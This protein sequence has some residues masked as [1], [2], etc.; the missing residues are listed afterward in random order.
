MEKT[1]ITKEGLEK[2]KEELITIKKV[3][4]PDNI[5]AIEE[6]RAH[7]DIS[8]NAEYHAAKEKQAFIEG[9]MNKLEEIISS[10]EVIE[11]NKGPLERI[12]F[13]AV[14]TTAMF[15][16]TTV[17]GVDPLGPTGRGPSSTYKLV[18][19]YESDPK[20]NRI[21]VTSPLGAALIGKDIG[22]II[23]LRAP[24]GKRKFE[25]LNIKGT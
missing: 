1:P 10:A 20:N 22:D 11:V 14:V 15:V 21:S 24:G 12:I 25:V 4:R 18:G 17:S 7:G 5:K 9:R 19:P 8:E 16:P 3:E 6:A 2:L 13:G 23:E